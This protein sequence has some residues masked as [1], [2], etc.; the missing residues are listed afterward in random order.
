MRPAFGHHVDDSYVLFSHRRLTI[1]GE[2]YHGE[3]IVVPH[4]Q[5]VQHLDFI[6]IKLRHE[7]A[8]I[9]GLPAF[10]CDPVQMDRVDVDD[11][12]RDVCKATGDSFSREPSV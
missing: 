8:T 11:R 9:V 1:G 12:V 6:H 10:D 3:R 7:I 5:T 4:E 2:A